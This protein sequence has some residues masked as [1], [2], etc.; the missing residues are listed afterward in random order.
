M[1]VFD[2]LG[3]I[4]ILCPRCR[5]DATWRF[6]DTEKSVMEV[7]CSDCGVFEMPRGEFEQ[8]ESDVAEPNEPA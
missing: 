3:P 6:L 4:E 8:A 7:V 1:R 5:A 2:E